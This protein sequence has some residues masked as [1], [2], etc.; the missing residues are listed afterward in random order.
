MNVAVHYAG[1]ADRA[2]EVGRMT[3]RS[4][5]F[6]SAIVVMAGHDLYPLG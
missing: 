2:G 3:G 4:T 1:N 5:T 6:A